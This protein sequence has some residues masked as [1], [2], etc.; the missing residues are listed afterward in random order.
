MDSN[1]S[2]PWTTPTW[3]VDYPAGSC[4][5]GTKYNDPNYDP[6]GTGVFGTN[7]PF[8]YP[9]SFVKLP[10]NAPPW[11]QAT[12]DTTRLQ[13]FN[14]GTFQVLLMDGSVKAISVNISQLTLAQAICQDDGQILGS[15]W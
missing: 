1:G 15:D 9:M 11:N 8:F 2:F 4:Q 13:A 10:Q 6:Q 12:C 3:W 7:Y 14:G 5:T